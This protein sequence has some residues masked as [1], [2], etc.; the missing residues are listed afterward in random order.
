MESTIIEPLK[1]PMISNPHRIRILRVSEF[2]SSPRLFS[3]RL[4]A[5]VVSLEMKSDLEDR[6]QALEV[7]WNTSNSLYTGILEASAIRASNRKASI[8]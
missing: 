8:P 1:N 2:I 3:H 6:P 5:L 7:A 4:G